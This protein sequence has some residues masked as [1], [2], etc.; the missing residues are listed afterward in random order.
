[1]RT[2]G[3]RPP[4]D[5]EN[6]GR[7]AVSDKVG[8]NGKGK[9]G[10]SDLGD[11]RRWSRGA[12]RWWR[13]A[14]SHG[15]GVSVVW[16]TTSRPRWSR[17]GAA[18]TGWRRHSAWTGCDV[19]GHGL[20]RPGLCGS[21]LG[22]GWPWSRGRVLLL[23][24]VGA[25]G[26][27]AIKG[28]GQLGDQLGSET[29]LVM[30][31]GFAVAGWWRGTARAWTPRGGARRDVV[32]GCVPWL[33]IEEEARQQGLDG[34]EAAA[35]RWL[36]ADGAGARGGGSM[37]GKTRPW[38]SGRC[39]RAF[40]GLRCRSRSEA[41]AWSWR[42]DRGRRSG[43]GRGQVRRRGAQLVGVGVARPGGGDLG[44]GEE[45]LQGGEAHDDGGALVLDE[46]GRGVAVVET[47]TTSRPEVLQAA[48]LRGGGAVARR[49]WRAAGRAGVLGGEAR[50]WQLTVAAEERYRHGEVVRA[51]PGCQRGEDGVGHGRGGSGDAERL[52]G[53]VAA[54][55]TRPCG[56]ARGRRA[57]GGLGVE[58]AC[59]AGA[60]ARLRCSAWRLQR[61][62][63]GRRGR[64]RGRSQRADERCPGEVGVA[65][66]SAAR[67]RPG[68]TRPWLA[69]ASRGR[70]RDGNGEVEAR[71][72]SAVVSEWSR[73]SKEEEGNGSGWWGLKR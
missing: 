9:V 32:P 35:V 22:T 61:P 41:A 48:R 24:V 49:P 56:R 53:V 34:A 14:A 29:V 65:A 64:S 11:H 63:A 62:S 72:S 21:W 54:G 25:P 30:A 31:P 42:R 18:R 28:E 3:P 38:G 71:C 17:S 44:V 16:W 10:T 59:E 27:D 5:S 40:A 69:A 4:C 33:G 13:D 2:A 50:R 6:I 45:E 7:K 23:L 70:W 1:M 36:G 15:R 26:D 57:A 51:R 46:V 68:R 67:P 52:G 39:G 37:E 73:G 8:G 58:V 43:S 47:G 19:H 12:A 55:K 20:E 60:E 66:P